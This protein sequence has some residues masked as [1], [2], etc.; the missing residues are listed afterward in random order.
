MDT[1][2]FQRLEDLVKAI[3]LPKVKA[4]YPLLGRQQHLLKLLIKLRALLINPHFC[5]MPQT[6][7]INF[8]VR[9][10]TIF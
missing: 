3:G 10:F 8:T 9:N 7:N 5:R 2:M 1:L 6:V 4:L